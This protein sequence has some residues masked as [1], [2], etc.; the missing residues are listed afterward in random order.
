MLTV[1]IPQVLCGQV[2]SSTKAEATLIALSA[3]LTDNGI[4]IVTGFSGTFLHPALLRAARL[5]VVLRGSHSLERSVCDAAK[6]GMEHAWRRFQ[7]F[8]LRRRH[9]DSR[10]SSVRADGEATVPQQ[11]PPASDPLFDAFVG[12]S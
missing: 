2:G 1:P 7:F 10:L 3:C 8:I 9:S 6:T 5:D 11:R 4:I 12:G